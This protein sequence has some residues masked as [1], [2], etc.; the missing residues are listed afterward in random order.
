MKTSIVCLVV[1]AVVLLF[2]LARKGDV[3]ASFK[4]LGNG[5]SLE[6]TDR[7]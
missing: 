1:I 3:K 6:A 2:A 4:V 7:K 5:F